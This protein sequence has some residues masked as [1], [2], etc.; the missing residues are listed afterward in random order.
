[1]LFR[2]CF[3]FNWLRCLKTHLKPGS[4]LCY[5]AKFNFSCCAHIVPFAFTN[6]NQANLI[7]KINEIFEIVHHLTR[8]NNIWMIVYLCK[9]FDIFINWIVHIFMCNVVLN[10]IYNHFLTSFRVIYLTSLLI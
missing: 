5:S 3:L 8:M 7:K 10:R 1:M 4:P 9:F 2:V 6:K